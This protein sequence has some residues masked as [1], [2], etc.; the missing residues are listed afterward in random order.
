MAKCAAVADNMARLA[1]YDALNPAVKAAQAEP[2]P[3]P[4]PAAVVAPPPAGAAPPADQSAWYDP[5]HVFGTSPSQQVRPEQ[6][7]AENLAPPPPPPGQ[8][9]AA[10]PAEPQPLDSISASVSEYSLNPFGK[11]LVILDNGQVWRQ[12]DSDGGNARFSRSNKNTVTIT[13]GLL[14]SYNLTVN[15]S[16]AMFKVKRLK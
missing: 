16:S 5:F 12:L 1:C 10:A 15:D 9:P 3:P 4:P 7:G 8:P 2:P 14:G 13:R 6:F 11:F